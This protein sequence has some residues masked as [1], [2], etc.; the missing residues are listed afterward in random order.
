[1][2]S[3]KRKSQGFTLVELLVTI[4]IV[5]IIGAAGIFTAQT[6]YKEDEHTMDIRRRQAT[7]STTKA[8]HFRRSTAP[9]KH[10]H[11]TQTGAQTQ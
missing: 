7:R 10:T 11:H 5:S 6:I 4:L 2:P 3:L 8:P 1:M 9:G